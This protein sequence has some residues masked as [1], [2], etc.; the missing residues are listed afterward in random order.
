MNQL[1][2][3]EK[4][5]IRG[6]ANLT[7]SELLAVVLGSGVQRHPVRQVAGQLLRRAG[8]LPSLSRWSAAQLQQLA[9][10]GVA[11]A[12]RLQASFELGRRVAAPAT[13]NRLLSSQE[14]YREV[15]YLANK[16]QEHLV[17]LYINARF[18]LLSKRTVSIGSLNSNLVQMR[19]IFEPALQLPCYGCFLSHNHP[20]GDATPSSDDVMVTQRVVE[21]G[22]LLGI[23]VFDHLVIGQSGFVSLREQGLLSPLD[24]TKSLGAV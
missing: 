12:T 7:E 6:S 1:L 11:G 14:V 5:I 21:A 4:V 17:V 24:N 18:E 13:P 19:D 8:D 9:G 23:E 15:A 3:R 22:Q 10:I 16:K 2:P 20:S